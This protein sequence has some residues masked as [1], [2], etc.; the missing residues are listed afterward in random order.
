MLVTGVSVVGQLCGAGLCVG[1]A[2]PI[3]WVAWGQEWRPSM[4]CLELGAPHRWP[5][6]RGGAHCHK[7]YVNQPPSV[8]ERFGV[9][10]VLPVLSL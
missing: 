10:E 8:M 5:V 7:N 9:S 4:L 6:V 3:W 2:S 1:P